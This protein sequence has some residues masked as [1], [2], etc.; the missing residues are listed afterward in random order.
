M[1]EM[2]LI[3][4]GTGACLAVV[5]FGGY[6]NIYAGKLK[7]WE[8]FLGEADEY[9]KSVQLKT[10]A[11]VDEEAQKIADAVTRKLEAMGHKGLEAYVLG[12]HSVPV[13]RKN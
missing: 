2:L 3:G 7:E 8:D 11:E 9:L 4:I 6:A 12:D 5:L 1:V 13:S 10:Q